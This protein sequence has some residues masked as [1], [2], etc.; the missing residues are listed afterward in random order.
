MSRKRIVILGAGY[1]GLG[2]ALALGRMPAARRGA[3]VLLVDRNPFHLLKTE[4]HAVAAGLLPR[5]RAA[6]SLDMLLKRAPVETLCAEVTGLDA[7]AGVLRTA[8]QDI[9][10][11]ALALAPGA[12]VNYYGIPGM[13][14]HAEIVTDL[15]PALRVRERVRELVRAARAGE[16]SR[17]V[18]VGAGAEGVE[19]AAYLQDRFLSENLA[20]GDRPEI[21]LVEGA[22]LIL[23]GG[24]YTRSVR[25]RARRRMEQYGIRMRLNTRVR[26]AEPGRLVVLESAPLPFDLLVWAGG[27]LAAPLAAEHAPAAPGPARRIPVSDMLNLESHKNIFVLG[28]AAL[29]ASGARGRALPMAAQY[30]VQQAGAAARNIAAVVLGRGRPQ[31]FAPQARGE[32][33]SIG[34]HEAVGWAGPVELLGRDAQALKQGI[35]ANYLASIGVNPLEWFAGRGPFARRKT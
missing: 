16:R 3:R 9:A 18:I 35:L 19:V 27:M 22:G 32:F 14:E 34:N 8:G 31:P 10:F 17:I 5:S 1:A 4:L 23:P 33:V 30:A 12:V 6:L 11:D 2:T 13:R 26:E 15:D 24:R 25:T 28:D 20:R 29:C 21:T 7:S